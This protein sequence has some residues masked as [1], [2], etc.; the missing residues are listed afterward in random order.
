MTGAD[1]DLVKVWEK[2]NAARF[3]NVMLKTKTVSARRRRKAGIKVGFEGAKAPAEPQVYDLV[4]V[5]VGRSPNGKK[6]DARQGGRGGHRS[7]LH[8]RRQADAHERG[9]HLRDRRHR[10]PAD[11]RAQGGARR[12]M[13]RPKPRRARSAFFDARQIPSVAYTDPEVAWAGLTEDEC[14]AQGIKY[15]KAVFPWAASGRAIANGRDEGF[16]KLLFDEATHRVHR[17]RHRRHARGRPD[18]RDLPRDRDGLRSGRHRQDDP[19][20]SDARANRS[21]WRPN[22]SKACAP[23]CRRRRRNSEARHRT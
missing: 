12:R 20:A 15:G 22:C 14:K 10:R 3:D 19:S 1:R 6:I 2:K 8:R 5:A 16:T 7:R 21:A 13:S 4:L 9:A 23:T 11:A 17:R 18:Q